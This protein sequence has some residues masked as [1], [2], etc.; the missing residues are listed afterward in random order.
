MKENLIQSE[1]I[2]VNRKY[3]YGSLRNCGYDNYSAIADILDNA[4]EP[5]VGATKIDIHTIPFGSGAEKTTESILICDN[6]CGMPFGVLR[7]A[8]ALGSDTGKEADKNLGLY[9]TGLKTAS[10]SIGK[11]LD[12]YTKA[13]DDKLYVAT[14]DLTK[15]EEK[16]KV[17][18]RVGTDEDA[19]FFSKYVEGEQG[20]IV[21]I[22]NLDKLSNASWYSFTSTINKKM[23]RC[24]YYIIKESNKVIS[25]NG[26]VIAPIKAVGDNAKQISPSGGYFEFKGQFIRYNAY[27]V[28]RT[29]TEKDIDGNYIQ[30]TS[31]NSGFYIFRQNRMVSNGALSLGLLGNATYKDTWLNGFRCEIFIDGT[32]DSI[33]NSSFTK[34]I[35]ESDGTTINQS[36]KDTLAK[37]IGPWI[38]QAK[39]TEKELS[40][41]AKENKE[42]QEKLDKIAKKQNENPFLKNPRTFGINHKPNEP[43]EKNPNP[44]E[45]PTK[46]VP[47][48][49]NDG[50][51]GG[52]VLDSRGEREQIYTTEMREDNRVYCVINTSH[53]FWKEFLAYH[54]DDDVI[55]NMAKL[56]SCQYAAL[57]E[58]GYYNDP[59]IEN[60][61]NEYNGQ[62]SE[63]MRKS[64]TY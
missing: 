8:L 26:D 64:M 13:M 57:K 29:T 45:T 12:V 58:C 60:A 17:A 2:R 33:F 50:W 51:F 30:R 21:K 54:Q 16:I 43:R 3:I 18:Y 44:K 32:C 31:A 61:I 48:K 34:M 6:G 47:H 53:I 7:E 46:R 4:V 56:W 23:G 39:T 63:E 42:M 20:T 37:E 24:F 40:K 19:K 62:I 28:P 25:I 59:K 36:F 35:G 41:E 38:V 15:N 14:L 11:T 55:E 9:G 27:F 5:E 22:S 49:R 1:E 52:Y 10:L